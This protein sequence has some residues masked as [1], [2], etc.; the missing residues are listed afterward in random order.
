MVNIP[1]LQYNLIISLFE[2]Y[3]LI[4]LRGFEFNTDTLT[5]FIDLYT[6]KYSRD[7]SRRET[8]FNNKKIRNVDYGLEE[9]NLHSESSFSPSFPE[10]VWFY[11][12]VP[13]TTGGETILCDGIKL[14]NSLSSKTKVFL[15]SE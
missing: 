8:R 13:P 7:A 4:L 3:G 15:I 11:C 5:S 9:G 1:D 12:H 2:K 14:W 10:I 6:E